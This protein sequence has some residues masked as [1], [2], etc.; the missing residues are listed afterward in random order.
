M[1]KKQIFFTIVILVI[2]GITSWF[3]WHIIKI[4]SK[5]HIDQPHNPDSIIINA[6]YTQMDANGN[7]HH[8]I[9]TP[10]LVH[11]SYQDATTFQNP[12]ITIINAIGNPWHITADKGNSQYGTTIINLL[13][14]VRLHQAASANNSEL[15]ITTVAATIYAHK[16]YIT[17]ANPVTVK[18][19]GI[20]ITAV[21]A[22]A[23]LDKKNINLLSQLKEQYDPEKK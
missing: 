17:T 2:A 13:N 18:K 22:N 16:K 20:I 11:Y 3:T 4:S 5:T 14:N 10:K 23:Y 1:N 6:T 15:T 12:D 7:I 21:G 19:P 9:H 8:I